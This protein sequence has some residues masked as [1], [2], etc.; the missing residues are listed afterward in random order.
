MAT[1]IVVPFRRLLPA[2]TV[3]A[4][5]LFL[6]AGGSA[7]APAGPGYFTYCSGCLC[8]DTAPEMRVP[9]DWRP[10][11]GMLG[12]RIVLKFVPR[13]ETARLASSCRPPPR[14]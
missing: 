12:G 9:G 7:A 5:G 14:A 4:A 8:E 3:V 1:L 6:F 10:S 13:D 11:G 2:A